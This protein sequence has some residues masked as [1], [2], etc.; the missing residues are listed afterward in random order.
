M[1]CPLSRPVLNT[2]VRNVEP[3][4]LFFCSVECS[5]RYPSLCAVLSAAHKSR[6]EVKAHW[7]LQNRSKSCPF[8]SPFGKALR[9]LSSSSDTSRI[10]LCWLYLTASAWQTLPRNR[11]CL[12]RSEIRESAYAKP[13]EFLC[14]LS[15]HSEQC[16]VLVWSSRTW[17]S[18]K[19]VFGYSAHSAKCETPRTLR[20]AS[21]GKLG[22]SESSVHSV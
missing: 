5:L 17:N 9:H 12:S 1:T 3:S 15:T 11:N 22:S 2:Y 20:S 8:V 16:E 18:A 6:S 21:S 7:C 14:E 13:Y 19:F 4:P 10:V